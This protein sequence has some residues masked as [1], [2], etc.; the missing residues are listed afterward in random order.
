MARSK[1]YIKPIACIESFWTIDVENRLSVSPILE[2]LRKRYGIRSVI[3]TCSTLDELRFNLEIVKQMK[4]GILYLAFHGYPGGIRLPEVA[5]EMEGIADLMGKRFKNWIVF[6]DSCT[7]LRVKEE[8]IK[9]FIAETGITMLVGFKNRVEW[10]DGA[11]VDLLVLERIQFYKD[12]RKFWKG[13]RR[14]Y[15]GLVGITGLDVYHK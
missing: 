14:A 9:K 6:F 5:V 10:L 3:L 11:A 4:G 7:T 2:L 1:T 8:R 13:F 15:K 12:M